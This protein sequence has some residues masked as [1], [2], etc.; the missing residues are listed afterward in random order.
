MQTIHYYT[1]FPDDSLFLK[2]M[3]LS[4]WLL[5]MLSLAMISHAIYTFVILDFMDPL[6]LMNVPWSIGAEPAV[7]ATI[8]FIV[9]LFLI[10]R[11]W[12]LN[13]M[14]LIPALILVILSVACEV[15]GIVSAVLIVRHHE[16]WTSSDTENAWM[17]MSTNIISAVV[18]VFITCII[19]F[20]LLKSRTGFLRT[21]RLINLLTTY[22]ITTG[23]IPTLI[24][25]G[26]LIAYYT[27]NNR[28]LAVEV[29]ELV[30]SK[31]YANTLLANLNSRELL[32]NRA[33]EAEGALIGSGTVKFG[34]GT[35]HSETTVDEEHPRSDT[36]HGSA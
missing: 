30:V 14:W 1:I 18:D 34:L 31:A 4:V 35:R 22:T 2:L 11:I 5:D 29:F 20:Q 24:C 10:H 3:V 6:A 19:C 26:T 12:Q 25:L 21:N 7:S 33:N 32:R 27:K 36:L 17:I 8:V 23:L 16:S 15:L 9:H 13:R 28:T